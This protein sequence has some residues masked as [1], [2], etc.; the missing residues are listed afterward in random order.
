[1]RLFG[2]DGIRGKVNKYPLT[3]ESVLKLSKAA[4]IVLSKKSSI[5]RVVVNKDT[6]LSGYIFEPA[7]TA[8]LI[9]MGMDVIL[10]GPLPTPALSLLGKSLRADFSIMIT[11]SHNPYQDNGL[12]FFNLNGLKISLEEEKKIEDLFF[13][14]DFENHKIKSNA[15]GKAVRL[16]DAIGR[17]SEA[18]KQN[19]DKNVNFHGMKIVLDTANGA[20]Y[21]VAPQILYELGVDLKTINNTPNG[22]NINADCGSLYPKKAS[23]EILK[24][25][26]NIGICLDGDAD[27]VVLIDERGDTLSGEEILYIIAKNYLKNK[28]LKKGSTI[29]SNEIA[30]YGFEE[31][32]KKIGINLLRVKVGDKNILEAIIKKGYLFGGEP[33]GHFI[34]K[35]SNLIGDGLITAIKIMTI[36]KKEN[37]KLSELRKDIIMYEVME[38]NQKIDRELFYLKQEK[39]YIDIIKIINNKKIFHSI[40]PSGTEPLLRVNLQYDKR[41]IKPNILKNIKLKIIK[42][43]SNA[44]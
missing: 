23:K 21:K 13:N 36:M 44:C 7:I 43:I 5:N 29:I 33:S 26:A 39:L 40:R 25:K 30:N 35:N 4:S 3:A 11:A 18:L 20:A 31:S 37:I 12:K 32:L 10:V 2:T 9:S 6:R 17:Y 27:R 22:I 34:F 41:S 38:I 15:L 8:G 42:K 14:Y 1:M 28:I 19:I 24:R 16:Q